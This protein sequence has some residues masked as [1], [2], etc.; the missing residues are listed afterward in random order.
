MATFF[1]F[2]ST[3]LGERHNIYNYTLT[4]ARSDI[5]RKP[6]AIA[7]EMYSE[8]RKKCRL[9]WKRFHGSTLQIPGYYPHSTF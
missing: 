6:G 8:G 9:A 4:Y 2:A 5:Q 7:I 1:S 3:A